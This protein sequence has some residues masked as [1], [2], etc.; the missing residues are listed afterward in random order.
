M[1]HRINSIICDLGGTLKPREV[2]ALRRT[3]RDILAFI[4][5]AAILVV[6]LTPVGHVF[7]FGFLQ[8]YFPEVFP[9]QFTNRRQDIMNKSH[10]SNHHSLQTCSHRRYDILRQ[11]LKVAQETS[12]QAEEDEELARASEVVARLTAPISEQKKQLIRDAL[13][14]RFSHFPFASNLSAI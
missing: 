4:P 3:A 2:A 8:R 10:P 1:I 6:P 5:F 13:V 9:S 12:S 11:Q 14:C 7:V